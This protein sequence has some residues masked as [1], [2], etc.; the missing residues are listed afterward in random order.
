MFANSDRDKHQHGWTARRQVFKI[1]API[2]EIRP[3]FLGT[4]V[5]QAEIYAFINSGAC[6]TN[7]LVKLGIVIGSEIMPS[8]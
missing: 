8:V 7:F 3:S 1:I 2:S 6:P 5:T 4:L